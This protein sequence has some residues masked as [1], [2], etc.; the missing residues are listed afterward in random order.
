MKFY[1]NSSIVKTRKNKENEVL[2]M[3]NAPTND[4]YE[5]F[6]GTSAI[7][8]L[9][10]D[11][12][13]EMDCAVIAM[14]PLEESDYEYIALLP[15]DENVEDEESDVLLYRYAEDENGE[16]LLDNIESDEEYDAVATAFYDVINE[17]MEDEDE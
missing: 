1:F 4:S 8:H 12:D 17:M 9:I 14:F 2:T 16:L 13:S 7:I 3:N 10:L 6:E 15:I 11:D 5:D